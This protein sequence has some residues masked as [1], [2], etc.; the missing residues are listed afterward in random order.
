MGSCCSKT[1]TEKDEYFKQLKKNLKLSFD[2]YFANNIECVIKL[3]KFDRMREINENIRNSDN[4]WKSYLLDKLDANNLCSTKNW[5]D[6]LIEYIEDSKF[7]EQYLFQNGIFFQEMLLSK[8]KTKIKKENDVAE[9]HF[10]EYEPIFGP[11]D[12]EEL[13]TYSQD[14]ISI[15]SKK[16]GDNSSFFGVQSHIKD[17]E[18][19]EFTFSYTMESLVGENINNAELIAKYNNYKLKIYIKIIR[20]H[21]EQKVHPITQVINKFTKLI[22]IQIRLIISTIKLN[23]NDAKKCYSLGLDIIN[24]VKHFIEIMQ[25]SLKLFYSKSINFK[26]FADE[27]DELINLIS[28]IIFND[29]TFYRHMT[30]LLNYMNRDKIE[31]LKTKFEKAKEVSPKE[32]GVH[33]K[34]CLDKTTDEYWEKYK[35]KKNISNESINKSSEN[36]TREETVITKKKE[37]LKKCIESSAS[38]TFT[39]DNKQKFEIYRTWTYVSKGGDN[40]DDNDDLEFEQS[41]NKTKKINVKEKLLDD[42]EKTN[43]PN[44]P[45]ISSQ[46]SSSTIIASYPYK[47][48]VDYLSQIDNFQVPLEKLIMISFISVI[49]VDSVDKFWKKKSSELPQEF[50][51]IGADEIM[52]IYLYIIYK[53]NL[54]NIIIQL[55]FVKHFITCMTKQSIFGYYY[56]TFEGCIRYLEQEDQNEKS[57]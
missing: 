3:K 30:H 18:N 49:I 27:K 40:I 33:P 39:E 53:L 28:Y 4:L 17:N 8:P 52:S 55:E 47:K 7:Y 1:K 54:S 2:S 31:I 6:D 23:Q 12:I 56:S 10:L 45:E 29:K 50:L 20:Q 35:K 38:E 5:K 25:V 24:E 41:F 9:F 51:S 43:L 11:L 19:K 57:K 32:C 13:K 26:Y 15:G 16:I 42:F 37:K 14:S 21:L 46:E 34:F 48:A 36:T 44:F 22:E